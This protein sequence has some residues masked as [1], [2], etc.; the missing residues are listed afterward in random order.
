ML[1]LGLAAILVGLVATAQA[2]Q[3]EGNSIAPNP[4]FAIIKLANPG[5]DSLPTYQLAAGGVL[6]RSTDTTLTRPGFGS[7]LQ[8]F[9]IAKPQ[10]QTVRDPNQDDGGISMPRHAQVELNFWQLNNISIP[11][12]SV[13][14]GDERLMFTFHS[15]PALI[16]MEQVKII[17]E[18]HLSAMLWGKAF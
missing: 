13:S 1:R 14:I 2:V 3:P 11:H 5:A 8:L 15:H 18:P 6:I 4:D 16:E 9:S 7:A 12:H 10:Q 17:L